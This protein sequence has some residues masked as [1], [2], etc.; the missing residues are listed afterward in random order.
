MD[1]LQELVA[2]E[3][4]K[5]TKARYCRFLDTKNWEG[6]A[7]VFTEDAILDVREDAGTDPLH[8][9]SAIIETVRHVVQHAETAHQVH[10]P[11]ITF[12]SPDAADVIWAMED[13]LVWKDGTS[14]IPGTSAMTGYGHYHEHYIRQNGLWL[15]ASVKLTR[16]NI[17]LQNTP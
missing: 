13:R 16:L 9:I 7:S 4:I 3:E 12:D 11:E 1:P 10:S 17:D 6:F 15:I 2:R 5:T 14:P 8:G